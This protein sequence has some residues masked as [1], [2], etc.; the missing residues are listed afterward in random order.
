MDIATLILFLAATV[1][2]VHIVTESKVGK[3]IRGFFDYFGPLGYLVQCPPC[4]GF[5]AALAIALAN[6]HLPGMM[7]VQLAL[8]GVA[9]NRVLFGMIEDPEN[10][11]E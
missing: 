5:W 2:L 10:E 6:V 9:V 3:P 7:Y 1:G 11:T 8:A 4:F